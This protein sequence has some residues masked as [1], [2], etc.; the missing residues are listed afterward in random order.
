MEH[1]VLLAYPIAAKL[2]ATNMLAY[3]ISAIASTYDYAMTPVA[4][5]TYFGLAISMF[6]IA[7]ATRVCVALRQRRELNLKEHIKQKGQHGVVVERASFVRNLSAT[8][9]VVFG[10][11]SIISGLV[12]GNAPVPRH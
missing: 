1:G 10:G 8:L 5:F 9:L 12:D 11:E 7:A 6:D 2:R 4:P 3:L